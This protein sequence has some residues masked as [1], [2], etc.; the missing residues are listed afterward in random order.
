MTQ[1]TIQDCGCIALP[2]DVAERLGLSPGS[3]LD[4]SLSVEGTS[5]ILTPT[6]AHPSGRSFEQRAACPLPPER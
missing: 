6:G 5:L 1:V 2:D 3:V 4:L